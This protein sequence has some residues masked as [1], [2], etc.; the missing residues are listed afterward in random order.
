[1][2]VRFHPVNKAIR[3]QNPNHLSPSQWKA[4][5]PYYLWGSESSTSQHLYANGDKQPP[6]FTDAQ[7][8][9]MAKEKPNLYHSNLDSWTYKFQP[10]I[11]WTKDVVKG[12]YNVF[13]ARCVGDIVSRV[14]WGGSRFHGAFVGHFWVFLTNVMFISEGASRLC[15][16]AC[17][18]YPL[19][20]SY[21][22][23]GATCLLNFHYSD[24]LTI[25]FS[26]SCIL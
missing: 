17:N 3:T 13:V 9:F 2:F 15:S 11:Y 10:Y 6:T 23:R 12:I 18:S 14:L 21:L 20:H 7:Y 16:I 1:M 22:W 8:T 24:K 4:I 5:D 19:R 25:Y 26:S